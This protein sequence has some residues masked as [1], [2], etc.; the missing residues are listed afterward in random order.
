MSNYCYNNKKRMLFFNMSVDAVYKV[1]ITM[2]LDIHIR[3][4]NYYKKKLQKVFFYR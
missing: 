3:C 1:K 4:L 2:I